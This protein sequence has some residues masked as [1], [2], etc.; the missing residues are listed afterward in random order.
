MT[1]ALDRASLVTQLDA[2]TGIDVYDSE[3]T[4]VAVGGPLPVTVF[5]TGIT[6]TEHLFA[7]RVYSPGTPTVSESQTRYDTILPAIEAGLSV[8][9]GPVDWDIEWRDDLQA[10]VATWNVTIG[11]QDF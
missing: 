5:C 3:P 6:R 4:T 8:Q 7:V 9:W 2:V 10:C 11:R 1:L